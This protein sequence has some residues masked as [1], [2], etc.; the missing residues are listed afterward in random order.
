MLILTKKLNNLN[1]QKLEL[2]KIVKKI[3]QLK[4]IKIKAKMR[5]RKNLLIISMMII[6]KLV[7]MKILKIPINLF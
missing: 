1:S 2:M 4:K 5:A 3:F 6:M 7:Q